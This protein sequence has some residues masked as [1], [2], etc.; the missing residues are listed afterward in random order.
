MLM[1]VTGEECGGGLGWSD[2]K[3]VFINPCLEEV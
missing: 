2:L 1:F 3:S